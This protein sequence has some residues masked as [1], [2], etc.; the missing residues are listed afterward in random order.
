MSKTID[1]RDGGKT[2][3]IGTP[4]SDS[5]DA[6]LSAG[7]VV[8][9]ADSAKKFGVD[10]LLHINEHGSL[11]ASG[12]VVEEPPASRRYL[13]SA[14]LPVASGEGLVVNNQTGA[15]TRFGSLPVRG[16]RNVPGNLK[17]PRPLAEGGDGSLGYASGGL[18]AAPIVGA[19]NTV[20]E[21][22]EAID[23]VAESV[24]AKAGTP[25]GKIVGN[26]VD[27]LDKTGNAASAGLAG[28]AGR[29][30]SDA[31][32]DP[33]YQGVT[34]IPAAAVD[35]FSKWWNEAP[36]VLNKAATRAAAPAVPA[37]SASVQQER[38]PAPGKKKGLFGFACGG[39][40]KRKF[41]DGGYVDAAARRSA[42]AKRLNEAFGGEPGAPD[43]VVDNFDGKGP[44]ITGG[45][46]APAPAAGGATPPPVEPPPVTPGGAAASA[47]EPAAAATKL[48]RAGML[49]KGYLAAAPVI[50]A[51]GTALESPEAIAKVAESVGA[52]GGTRGG[53]IVGNAVDFLDKTGNAATFGLA[54]AA[55][56][57]L[58][59]AI[60]DPRYQGATAIPAA[61][62][63]HFSQ[64]WNEAPDTVAT[65][66]AVPKKPPAAPP[67]SAVPAAQQAA[68]AVPAPAVPV[69]AARYL[70]SAAL[71]VAP[72]QGLIVN[73]Q[74]GAATRFGGLP[75]RNAADASPMREAPVMVMAAPGGGGVA[76]REAVPV[77]QLRRD[78]GIFDALVDAN[79]QVARYGDAR[80]AERLR[81]GMA[82]QASEIGLRNAQ[83]LEAEQRA[84]GQQLA[85]ENAVDARTLLDQM[86]AL[87]PKAPDYKDARQKL[88]ARYELRNPTAR[89]KF[90][91]HVVP[92]DPLNG[93]PAQLVVTNTNTG[94]VLTRP[95]SGLGAA[96]GPNKPTLA[97]FMEQ[98]RKFPQNKQKSDDELKAHWA[99][100]Y[101]S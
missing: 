35:H 3:N 65:P 17:E 2:P 97:Q 52:D 85:L 19:A 54:G 58:S 91:S 36:D 86:D 44:K 64:W 16:A 55:G 14:A 21:T 100:R 46:R 89:E 20:L 24:G 22:P 99:S 76:P 70:E 59:D 23:K 1:Y 8:V 88:Q 66:T 7:E 25:A 9:K 30:A 42:T 77:P 18:I 13:E 81:R 45:T 74:T 75:V 98:A 69:P 95:V 71:P 10:R 43:Y 37:P 34:A 33:K 50:G 27:F 62:A 79:N 47:A 72:G 83:Q 67:P 56:R 63:D 6:K 32:F 93:T 4:T 15:A 5:I 48:A 11:P 29:V 60:S 101:A 87:D 73:D 68:A 61:A 96:A 28:A 90:S 78:G 57:V 84:A 41:A 12:D 26:A 38:Q 94:D 49:A 51:V 92:A 53:N 80:R 39:A 40:V 82:T 31:L